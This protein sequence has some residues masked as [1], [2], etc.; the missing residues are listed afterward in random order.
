M[1]NK[2]GDNLRKWL[3]ELRQKRQLS[4]ADVAA[5]LDVSQGYYSLIENS[6]RQS[7]LN[8]STAEKLSK[9]FKISLKKISEF[10][11]KK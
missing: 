11:S 10:E 9:I 5:M 8:L 1:R 2:G 7:D 6:E 4:Q 3:I